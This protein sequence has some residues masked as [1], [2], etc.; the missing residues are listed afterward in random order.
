MQTPAATSQTIRLAAGQSFHVQGGAGTCIVVK[1][2]RVEVA[3]RSIWLCDRF[4]T[5]GGAVR[6]GEQYTLRQS[7]WIALQA[8]EPTV[9]LCMAP[10]KKDGV[11][12]ALRRLWAHVI[13]G[14]RRRL[15]RS[16]A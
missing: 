12:V 3:E 2:G 6:D 5:Q 11:L 10:A 13:A 1:N 16:P 14:L 15:P 8:R 7:G 4:V 9:L